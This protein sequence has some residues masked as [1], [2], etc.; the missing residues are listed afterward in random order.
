[1]SK[2]NRGARRSRARFKILAMI[3]VGAGLSVLGAVAWVL[4]PKSQPTATSES[5][6]CV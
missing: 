5:H 4:L 2:R 1:M 3:L 6:D